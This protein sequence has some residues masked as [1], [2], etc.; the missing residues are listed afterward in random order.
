MALALLVILPT[1]IGLLALFIESVRV[2]LFLLILAAIGHFGITVTLLVGGS[3]PAL[4]QILVLDSTGLLFLSIASSLFLVVSFYTVPYVLSGTHDEQAAPQHFVPCLLWFLA[5]MTF[6][7]VTQNLAVQWA[8][9]EATTLASAPLVYFYK[10]KE[11]L[12]AAWKYLL[13]CSVGIALALLGV[14][15]LGIAA[16]TVKAEGTSLQL[17]E[18][19]QTAPTMSRT[20]L[21][22][23]FVLALVGFGTKKGLAPM[24]TWLPDTHSQ[25]PSPV[26]A[27]LSGSLLNC[28]LLAI[29]RFYQVCL[30][31]GDAGFARS[32]LLILGFASLIVACAFMLGQR[33]YER[34][35]AYS[36]IE[37]MGI[38]TVG[39][40][41]GGAAS[42]GAMLHAV[43]HSICKAGLF[44]VA[45]NILRE[46]GTTDTTQIRGVWRRL[47]TSGFLIMALLLA[48]GGTPP[49]GPFVSEW[50]IF[51][52]AV[53]QSHPFAAAAFVVLLALCF[54]GMIGVVLPML[55]GS[56]VKPEAVAE[57]KLSVFAPMAMLA[58]SLVLGL[59]LPTFLSH[60]TRF[61]AGAIGG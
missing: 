39:I 38:I 4:G 14:F 51:Q 17:S 21:R 13:I 60:L 34:L 61:A 22:A 50:L 12:E 11:A 53:G 57:P 30:A 19:M 3:A 45:G 20:W 36:S 7:C 55:Q 1:L 8:A 27:L 58:A 47:P 56:S 42:N 41:F 48:L 59:Y 28:A 49:F 9:I 35:F 6:V 25:A 54:L 18:L 15:F 16:S 29:L 32:M 44:M 31:S 40:G 10:R 26:S 24:H 33:D 5:S 23:A 37:N 46:F 43:N 52:S 2:D